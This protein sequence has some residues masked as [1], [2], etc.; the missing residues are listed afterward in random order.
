MKKIFYILPF[1]SIFFFL[2]G[3]EGHYR[4][5][6]QDPVNWGKAECSNDVC[7]AEGTCTADVL[8][9]AG[10][11]EFGFRPEVSGIDT[12]T[13]ENS[14]Q[15]DENIISNSGCSEPV[16]K[17]PVKLSYRESEDVRIFNVKNRMMLPPPPED[18]P[19]DIL[20]AEV[21]L[22][23]NTIVDTQAHNESAQ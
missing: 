8:A 2:K 15:D 18:N 3:C 14:L 9:P 1:V 12:D 10:S 21:P 4:Y 6:C 20:P 19:E 7:K 11:R 16:A 5:P 23:Y 22:D 17:Q 13:E